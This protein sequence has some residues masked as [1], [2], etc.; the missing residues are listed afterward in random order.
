MRLI[1]SL[2]RT[3][4]DDFARIL[5]FSVVLRPPRVGRPRG[6]RSAA[7]AVIGSGARARR[8]LPG[9]GVGVLDALVLSRFLSALLYG[10]GKRDPL[11]F[12]GVAVMLGTVA[13]AA[14]LLP[15][16]GGATRPP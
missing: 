8:A 12:A 6:A 7:A 4:R 1:A 15:A 16:R 3:R 11:T 2:L 13:L 9:I 14:S 5:A 10:I